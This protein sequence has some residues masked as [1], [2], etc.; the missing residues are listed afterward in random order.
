MF[1]KLIDQIKNLT[2]ADSEHFDPATLDDPVALKTEWSPLKGGGASF[3]T[4]KLVQVSP[5]RYEFRSA[6]GAIAF[7]LIF[8]MIGL[9]LLVAS[10]FL[11]IESGTVFTED[12][13]GLG[14]VGLIFTL[15]GGLMFYFGTKPVVFDKQYE[16]FWTG[17][18]PTDELMYATTNELLMP[19]KE[20]HA[21]Q[22]I[23]EYVSGNKSSYFSYEM[24][25]VSTEGV[26]TNVVDHG[27]L[28]QIHED[29]RT[30]SEFLEV[31]IWDGI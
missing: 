20:I 22:L 25:L 17:R 9:G 31:P 6:W 26:R 21:I 24:N 30:L 5:L 14:A 12:V 15:A 28:D 29:A 2:T 19:F 27:K 1:R 13:I 11:V 8:L 16:C 3:C 7:Y 23:S 18:I 4:R 10:I